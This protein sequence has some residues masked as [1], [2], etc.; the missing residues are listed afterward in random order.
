MKILVIQGH[1]DPESFTRANALHYQQ[2]ATAQG[3]DVDI[4]DLS[5][6]DFDPV[7][8]YGYRQHMA[9]ESKPNEYQAKIA[10]AD[11][12]AFFFPIWWGAE[13]ALLKGFIDRT[14]TP[15]FA[16]HYNKQGK[17]IPLLK[18]KSANLFC[19]SRGAGWLYHTALAPVTY[20][21][22]TFILGY[23]GVKVQKAHFLGNMGSQKDTQARRQ[24]FMEQ[25]AA[26][27]NK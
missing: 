27:L 7:L 11:H 23:T 6:E 4:I 2:A 13:P 5:Q 22:K 21:W 18:G 20:R 25:C 17:L 26:T 9:D 16:Y 19:S 8:R 1:P 3:H 14:F 12:L 15:R 10:A 24:N